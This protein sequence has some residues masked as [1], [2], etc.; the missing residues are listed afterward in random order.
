VVIKNENEDKMVEGQHQLIVPADTFFKVQ[1]I[2]GQLKHKHKNRG[3]KTTD[4]EELVL[5]RFLK[6][7]NAGKHLLVAVLKAME[8]YIL[9]SLPRWM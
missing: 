7:G 5:R 6:C 2:L 9:L 4:R 3:Q 1:S 8:A